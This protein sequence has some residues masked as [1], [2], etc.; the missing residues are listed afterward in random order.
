MERLAQRVRRVKQELLLTMYKSVVRMNEH[1][2]V[3]RMESANI[4]MHL[5]KNLRKNFEQLED[6]SK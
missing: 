4:E 5:Q 6:D 3:G 1:V 2:L